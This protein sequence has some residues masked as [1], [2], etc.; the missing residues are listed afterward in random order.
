MAK[1]SKISKLIEELAEEMAEDLVKSL[2]MEFKKISPGANRLANGKRR[3][4]PEASGPKKPG[5]SIRGTK[6]K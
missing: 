6:R 2:T 4:T 5:W 1:E 3:S